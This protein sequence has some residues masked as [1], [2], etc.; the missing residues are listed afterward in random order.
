M[1]VFEKKI[2]VAKFIFVLSFFVNLVTYTMEEP[3]KNKE[4]PIKKFKGL[5]GLH[6]ELK[7]K[8]LGGHSQLNRVPRIS[9]KKE[10]QQGYKHYSFVVA[11]RCL[12]LF[13]IFTFGKPISQNFSSFSLDE[14]CIFSP[15]AKERERYYGI[16]LSSTM[17]DLLLYKKHYDSIYG[18]DGP[19]NAS[20]CLCVDYS[21]NVFLA[22]KR[23]QKNINKYREIQEPGAIALCKQNDN[24]VVA[25]NHSALLHYCIEDKAWRG[26]TYANVVSILKQVAFITPTVILALTQDSNLYTI[27]LCNP[28]EKTDSQAL[29]YEQSLSVADG[30]VLRPRSF[31]VNSTC[32]WLVL[33]YST[34]D[35]SLH[36]NMLSLMNLKEQKLQ[37]LFRDVYIK[38]LWFNNDKICWLDWD[39][40]LHIYSFEFLPLTI[41]NQLSLKG[42]FK[43]ST[44][45]LKKVGKRFLA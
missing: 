27:A 23:F 26:K 43:Y 12:G 5:V 36:D 14:N 31:A 38:R 21:C 2:F 18:L 33:I 41:K 17:P 45:S 44:S 39:Q 1:K 8:V 40:Q 15:K 37:K 29:C 20:T 42:G 32:P 6:D 35:C 11:S 19:N 34:A 9:I 7:A 4:K 24:Y 25:E 28:N 30:T 10:A 22:N 16:Q 13:D 3:Q